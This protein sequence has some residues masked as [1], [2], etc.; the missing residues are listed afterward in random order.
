VAITYSS[1]GTSE[2]TAVSTAALSPSCP[3]TINAGDILIA[4]ICYNN[5]TDDPATPAN[6]E[7]LGGPFDIGTTP[8]GRHWIYGKI[9]DGTEDGTSPSWG[10]STGSVRKWGVIYRF[11][12]RVSG[13]IT[14]LVPAASFD[15]VPHGT[16]PQ[17]PSVTTTETGALAVACSCQNDNNL[18]ETYAGE[19]GG[20]WTL[21]FTA[22]TTGSTQTLANSDLALNDCTPTA[23]PGTVSGGAMT[24]TNDPSG[25]IGFEIRTQPAAPPE[26][27][28]PAGDAL[29]AG[30]ALQPTVQ[31]GEQPP[32]LY[33]TITAPSPAAIRS[34]VW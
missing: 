25:T 24:V 11:L 14:Q 10:T 16:D 34:A 7:L 27:D 22:G 1:V 13:T 28:A 23:D 8:D 18:L 4:H 6:W 33:R 21:R 3:A 29:A 20:S 5:L 30:E 12:G 26:T 2:E 15:S 32:P 19:A 9:A 17:A 31:A